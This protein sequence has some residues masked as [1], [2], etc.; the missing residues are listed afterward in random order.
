MGGNHE[1]GVL[2]IEVPNDLL[3]T[4]RYQP[5]DLG[6]LV[7]GISRVQVQMDSRMLLG[8]RLAEAWRQ[9]RSGAFG[10]D[11]HHPVVFDVVTRD[12]PES[13]H[14]NAAA[15]RT[16]ESPCTRDPI[17]NMRQSSRT[18]RADRV[19]AYLPDRRFSSRDGSISTGK[20]R[21]RR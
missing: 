15:R 20:G 18:R 2:R 11:Q 10:R 16:S 19:W 1:V 6:G 17:R 8:G 14:Q 4:K 3:G 9:L 12:V 7:G 13:L 5:F 21:V